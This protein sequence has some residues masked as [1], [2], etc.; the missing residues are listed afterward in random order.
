MNGAGAYSG[1]IGMGRKEEWCI[2]GLDDDLADE[3]AMDPDMEIVTEEQA[4][5]LMEAWRID[6]GE[7][8][9]FVQ[10]PA[11]IQAIAAKQAAGI[12]LTREDLDAL[13]PESPVPGINKRLKSARDVIARATR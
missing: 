12:P 7:P 5:T 2:I 9:E 3:Y 4:D 10:D 8:E 13:D 11:R 6:K 1:G